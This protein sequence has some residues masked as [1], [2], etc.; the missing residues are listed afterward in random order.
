MAKTSFRLNSVAAA[1]TDLV[2]RGTVTASFVR[3]QPATLAARRR[4][5]ADAAPKPPPLA[6]L[7]PQDVYS[8]FLTYKSGTYA[9]PSSGTPLGGHAVSIIGYGTD[10]AGTDFWTVRNSWNN[11]WGN[12]G[13]FN[14]QRGTNTCGFESDLVAGTV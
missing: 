2:A 12:G 4:L 9:C 3:K 14:I 13:T 6:S 10:A 7:A 5:R 11:G 1:M 8:D